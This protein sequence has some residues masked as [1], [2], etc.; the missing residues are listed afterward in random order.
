MVERD[1]DCCHSDVKN[2]FP[3]AE[4]PEEVWMEV[5]KAVLAE[6]PELA[7]SYAFV[8]RALYGLGHA[9]CAWSQH[10]DKW[11]RSKGYVSLDADSCLYVL[12]DS[13]GHVQAAAAT[14]VDD[15]VHVGT[16]ASCTAYRTMLQ[17]DFETS[18][19]DKV[20]TDFLGMQI[21]RDREAGTLKIS[22]RS[23]SRRWQNGM[24]SACQRARAR[25]RLCRTRPSSTRL[26]TTKS[27]AIQ[28]CLGASVERCSSPRTA[29]GLM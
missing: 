7:D 9:P 25:R 20:P 14:F 28:A 11:F 24:E 15:C 23:T 1:W 17:A 22:R 21:T 29:A 12:Y 13:T 19:Q 10:L 3:C 27:G 2:A 6:H 4:L 26:L 8:S 16:Q 5:P 18:G